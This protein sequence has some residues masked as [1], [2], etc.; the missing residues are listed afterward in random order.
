MTINNDIQ[1]LDALRGKN[2]IVQGVG[3]KRET[4]FTA[5]STNERL[6]T[7]WLQS[8][9]ALFCPSLDDQEMFW[10]ATKKAADWQLIGE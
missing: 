5:K 1:L 9:S 4:T 8:E 7:K 10:L 6:I 3:F 2:W